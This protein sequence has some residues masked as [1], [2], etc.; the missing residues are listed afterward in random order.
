[1]RGH[2]Q[3]RGRS[4]VHA[5]KR[6][7]LILSAPRAADLVTV[8]KAWRLL[9]LGGVIGGLLG[10]ATFAIAPP[11]Y[12]ARATVNVDFHLE[13]AWPQNTDREQFYYLERE[14]RKLEEIAF[15]DSVLALVQAKV[16]VSRVGQLRDGKLALSQPG[17][18]GWHFY[19]DDPNPSVAASLAGAW[20]AAFR[21]EVRRELAA[22][23]SSDLEAFII[24]DLVQAEDLTPKRLQTNGMYALVGSIIGLALSALGALIIRFR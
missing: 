13:Q 22:G 12:R 15:S 14:T 10:A 4:T 5:A 2:I 3:K 6:S 21:D 20:A 19:A 18:G 1:M 9:L 24:V 23:S 8:L 16:P 11:P 17:N 7:G